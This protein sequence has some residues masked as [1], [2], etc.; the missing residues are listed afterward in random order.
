MA[1]WQALVVAAVP[2]VAAV[3][4][5]FLGFRDLGLRRRLETSKQFLNLFATAHG[6]PVDGRDGVGVGEQ[7]ATLHLIAD[8]ASKESL[9]RNAAI[10][11]LRH[12]TTWGTGVEVRAE[13]LV[14]GLGNS[15]PEDAAIEA[16]AQAVELL[17]RRTSSQKEIAAAATKALAR[18][19]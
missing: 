16:A 6:R 19:T 17:S 14:A 4:T 3:L 2:S 11:G 5:A 8:F 10:E 9:V 7:V 18:L 12:F 15:M 1:F 13:D